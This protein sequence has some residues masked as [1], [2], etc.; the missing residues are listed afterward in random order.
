MTSARRPSQPGRSV[1]PHRRRRTTDQILGAVALLMVG[2][3]AAFGVQRLL[4]GPGPAA[5]SA[6]SAAPTDDTSNTGDAGATD[7]IPSDGP[8]DSVTPASPILERRIPTSI[9][10]VTLSIQSAIDATSLSGGPDGRALDAAVVAL[11]KQ[12]SDLEVA[13]ADD[14]T[15]SIDLTI[16]G[17]RVD[18]I[19]AAEIRKAVM[20]AWL[21]AGTS[22]VATSS[23]AVSGTPVTKV[24]YGDGGADEYVLTIGDSVFVLE[25]TDAALA[26]SAAAALITPSAAP[27][28]EASPGS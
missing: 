24:S 17:F 8:Q 14:Q 28:I 19:A 27:T 12:A 7:A 15:A 4:Q 1:P 21:A 5:S 9:N 25:T 22:G 20:E 16:I 11:G 18:G 3:F 13:V 26:Q 6:P 23:I 10:G 2:A